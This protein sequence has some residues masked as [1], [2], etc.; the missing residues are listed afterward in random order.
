[1]IA[2][3]LTL[4]GTCMSPSPGSRE[5]CGRGGGRTVG[6]KGLGRDRERKE[7]GREGREREEGRKGEQARRLKGE[8]RD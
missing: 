1:M 5:H 8:E 2:E 7:G 4:N 3:Y 6:I